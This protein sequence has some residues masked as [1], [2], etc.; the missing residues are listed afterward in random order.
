LKRFSILTD[1][2][3]T[4]IE[5]GRKGLI[6]KHE[7]F[8]GRNRQNSIKYGLVIPLCQAEHHNQYQSRGIHFDKD[9]CDKWQRIGQEKFEEVYPDL[10]FLSIFYRNYKE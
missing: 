10:D 2:L 9:L 6:N 5:C 4:C 8:F 7:I 1:D 3:T